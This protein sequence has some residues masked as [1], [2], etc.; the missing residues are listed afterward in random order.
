MNSSKF[1]IFGLTLNL[2][3]ICISLVLGGLIAC[4]TF[5]GSI[6]ISKTYQQKA[7]TISP[8]IENFI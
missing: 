7:K 3:I 6:N 1:N 8:L 2:F 4:H 5:C